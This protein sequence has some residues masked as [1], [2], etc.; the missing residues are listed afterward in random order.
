[1]P[2]T[3]EKMKHA[4]TL[5]CVSSSHRD[6]IQSL[7]HFRHIVDTLQFLCVALPLGEM[8]LSAIYDCSLF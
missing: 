4:N 2:E 7:A 1:M 8:G 6:G 3:Y 5:C